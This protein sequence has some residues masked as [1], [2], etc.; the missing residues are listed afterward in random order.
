MTLEHEDLTL[1]AIKN[2]KDVRFAIVKSYLQG[3]W[4]GTRIAHELRKAHPESE[5]S[6]VSGS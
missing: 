4:K 3:N 5:E 1:K 2:L 6:D